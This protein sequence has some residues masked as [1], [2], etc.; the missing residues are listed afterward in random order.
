MTTAHSLPGDPGPDGRWYWHTDRQNNITQRRYES[1]IDEG[2]VSAR[3]LSENKTL[4][5]YKTHAHKLAA[6]P[7][8]NPPHAAP[9]RQARAVHTPAAV[10]SSVDVEAIYAARA[11]V[12]PA[13]NSA[14]PPAGEV[15][16][17]RAA[18]ARAFAAASGAPRVPDATPEA[19]PER[20]ETTAAAVYAR[21]AVQVA[22][23]TQ[24]A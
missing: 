12:A 11:Q 22:A 15:F 9:S 14:S 24:E 16:E 19:A 18:Q 20:A 17:R 21:R 2:V 23:A 4:R 1:A 7:L 3:E 6:D 10:G 8:P 13:E 5:H